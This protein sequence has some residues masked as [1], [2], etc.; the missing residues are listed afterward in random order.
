MMSI[1]GHRPLVEAGWMPDI[2]SWADHKRTLSW[3][4][5]VLRRE[6]FGKDSGRWVLYVPHSRMAARARGPMV[7]HQLMEA[8]DAST[9]RE[10]MTEVVEA[11]ARLD[12]GI[13]LE[14]HP[15]SIYYP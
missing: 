5:A 14:R 3:G 1:T 7:L 15:G 10:D 11:L 13:T 2:N 9:L 4:T 6:I 8:L 12:P